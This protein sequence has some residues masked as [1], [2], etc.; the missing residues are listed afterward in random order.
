MNAMVRAFPPE[1]GIF[2]KLIYFIGC[3]I[4]LTPTV[5]RRNSFK[6]LGKLTLRET[7]CYKL[8]LEKRS[9]SWQIKPPM[10]GQDFTLENAIATLGD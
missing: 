1:T 10:G 8:G 5:T 3:L 9:S 4:I 2:G 7:L 6:S